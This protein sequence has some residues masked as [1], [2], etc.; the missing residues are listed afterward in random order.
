MTTQLLELL[1]HLALAGGGLAILGAAMVFRRQPQGLLPALA[2]VF[3]L[4]PGLWA[5][6]PG[7]PAS[8]MT[9]FFAGLLCGI[10]LATIGQLARYADRRGFG[11]DALYGLL[12]W[13]ALGMLLLAESTNW[14]ML[15]LG[16][17]LASLCLYALV[18]ARLDDGLGAEAALKYFLPGAMALAT[19]VFGISLIYAGSGTLYITDSLAAGGPIVAAG[20]AL[21]LIGIGFKLS[22]A[23]VHLWTPDVY[24]GAPAPIA[25]FLS[26]GSKAAAAAALLH[27]AADASPDAMAILLPALLVIAGLTMAAGNIG[28]LCQK[29]VKRL[30]AFSSIA[31]MGYVAMAAL[32][33]A[34]GGGEAALFYL[35]AYALMDLGAFGAVGALSG[36]MADRDDIESYRGLGYVHPWRAGVLTICL[37]S[38]AGLPPTAGFIGKFLVFGAALRAGFTTLAVFG[39][40]MAVIG[41]FY[42]LRLVATLY[43]REA[44][45]AYPA[46]PTPAGPAAGLTLW[47]VAA[48]I[49]VLGLFPG[50]LIAAITRLVGVE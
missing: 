31:Q 43:M 25:A 6:W 5:F 41:V 19:L 40:L 21:A 50:P 37:L 34:D 8:G 2:A 1:P 30:L 29:S 23:P 45:E 32:A 27:L 42:A 33:V 38:L 11:G 16:L 4:I 46:V 22:L 9:R 14:I 13:S 15:L 48:G 17:E 18:A 39:I 49:L 36:E 35:G 7:I 44:V 28:A 24:Q 12:L 10:T 20:L 3:A 26:T 47:A